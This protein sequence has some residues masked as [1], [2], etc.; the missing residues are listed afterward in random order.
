MYSQNH[1]FRPLTL[2]LLFLITSISVFA[3]G[4]QQQSDANYEAI[5]HVLVDSGQTGESLPR[6]L[7]AVSR[8]VKDEFGT[9]KLRLINT[10]LGRMSNQG[11]FDYKGISNAYSSDQQ[12][13]PPSFLEWNLSD[14]KPA[15]GDGGQDIY[16]FQFFRFG[17]RVPIRGAVPAQEEKTPVVFNYE[18]LGLTVSRLNVRDNS[19]TLIGTLTQPKTEATLFLVLTVRN[20]D[21]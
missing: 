3:Q 16:Q 21:K 7:D 11:R 6:S 5:L 4:P 20:V 12:P 8:Q 14:L 18:N 13:A 19:P 9:S 17:A 15:K 2:S 10:Y 1:F